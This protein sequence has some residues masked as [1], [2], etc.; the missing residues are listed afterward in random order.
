M[1]R[2][3]MIRPG[4]A[5]ILWR[6]GQLFIV[7]VGKVI[8]NFRSGVRRFEIVGIQHRARRLELGELL[9]AHFDLLTEV[10]AG[11]GIVLSHFALTFCTER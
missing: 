8:D 11:I 9:L 5:Q 2:I 6:A 7:G 10:F 4:D 3:A 1:R